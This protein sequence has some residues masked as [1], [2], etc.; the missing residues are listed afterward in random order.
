MNKYLKLIFEKGS[1]IFRDVT[2]HSICK[3]SQLCIVTF[4]DKSVVTFDMI[5]LTSALGKLR[6]IKTNL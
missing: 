2:S 1:V 4:K 6:K 5:Y 3:E